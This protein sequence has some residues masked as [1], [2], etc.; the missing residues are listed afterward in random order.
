MTSGLMSQRWPVKVPADDTVPVMAWVTPQWKE[1]TSISF[2]C[3]LSLDSPSS[4]ST[5]RTTSDGIVLTLSVWGARR[6]RFCE[7]AE[8][9]T[10]R[11]AS[12]CDFVRS[13]RNRLFET[14]G[15]A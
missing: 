3:L 15:R 9:A 7:R 6:L 5:L 1:R 13:L 10:C 14:A 11:V 12:Q 2:L 4:P 8:Q